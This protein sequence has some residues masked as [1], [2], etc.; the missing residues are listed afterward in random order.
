MRR[1]PQAQP[2]RLV[3]ALSVAAVLAVFLLYTSIAGGGTPVALA[4]RARR[5]DEQG[6]RSAGACRPG[7]RATRT[8][9]ASVSA[10]ATSGAKRPPCR[11]ST[12]A[13]CRTVPRRAATSS[14][15]AGSRTALRRRRGHAGDE[16]PV[17]VHA[18]AKRH[19][20]SWPSSVAPRSP[21]RSGSSL[22]AL[23]AGAAA[24]H[25][26]RRRLALSAQNALIAALRARPP[27]PRACCSPRSSATTSRSTTS[28]QH[29]SRELPT[30]YTIS[31]FWGGQE[32]SLLLWLLVLTGLLGRPR[33]CSS[34]AARATSSRGSC[35]CSVP[36]PSFFALLLVAVASPFAT[37][38]AAA[39][40]RAQPEPPEPVHGRP[41]AAPLPRLRRP[42]R[43]VRVRDGRA[44]L[45]PRGRALDRRDAPLD[46]VR[47][48]VPRRRPAARRALG[49]RGGRLG[50]LLRLGSRRER[51]ADALARGDGVPALGDDPGEARDAAGLEHG[52]RR[53]RVLRSRSSAR[54]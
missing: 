31:A 47:V 18:E 29:T 16:V 50:R 36:S 37:Q 52:A 15:R 54:S 34:A 14:S 17:E 30:G 49:L 7:A 44:A 46:A 19:R 53:A 32:G 51:G 43:P 20:S 23:V 13:R 27:S 5:H 11:S 25:L 8:P 40:G 3:I 9:A 35:R 22:Y 12:R 48:G 33:C 21:S 41:P 1:G 6:G 28:P 24:A 4:E 26:R 2:A 38:A 39:T 42:D 10:S 45:A